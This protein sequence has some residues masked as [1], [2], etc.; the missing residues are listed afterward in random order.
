MI[1][2]NPS[3][4]PRNEFYFETI[5]YVA[6]YLSNARYRHFEP[7]AS[8]FVI[9][10]G[11]AYTRPIVLKYTLFTISPRD[12]D[13]PGQPGVFFFRLYRILFI[14]KMPSYYAFFLRNAQSVFLLILVKSDYGYHCRTL[15][16]IRRRFTQLRLISFSFFSVEYIRV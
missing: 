6:I 4:H 14:G 3:R 5:P 15:N 9:T 16:L 2:L 11:K 13:Y 7:A 8:T 1:K 10:S 12:F